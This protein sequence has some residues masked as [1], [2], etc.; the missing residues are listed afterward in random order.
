MTHKTL[1]PYAALLII[2]AA[3]ALAV[4]LKPVACRCRELQMRTS[5]QAAGSGIMA[6]PANPVTGTGGI[7]TADGRAYF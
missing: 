4:V 6:I 3:L 5:G 1:A 7:A 2:P